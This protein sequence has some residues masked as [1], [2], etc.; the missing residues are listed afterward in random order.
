MEIIKL[1]K[2]KYKENMVKEGI[3]IFWIFVIG[4]LLG[5]IYEIIIT[6]FKLG[7]FE[8]RQGL[9]YGPFIP[10]Y[11]IGGIAYYIVLKKLKIQKIWQVFFVSMFLGGIT[12]YICSFVQ[13]KIWGTISW[14]YSYLPFNLNG[15]TSLL[16]CCYWGIAGILYI[17]YIYPIVQKID[18]IIERKS[19]LAITTIFV[20]FMVF[21]IVI[22]TMA[23]YRQ[24]QRFNNDIANNRI[25][26]WFDKTYPDEYLN[27]VFV[28][29]K[30]VIRKHEQ[31]INNTSTSL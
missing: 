9:I 16:H 26:I 19:F 25:E 31:F 27:K 15:R 20:C 11:G 13:E 4:S 14:D 1:E 8:N 30:Y 12:E 2:H 7:H 10:V 23:A 29:K 28:N 3:K 22:S 6:Y 21:N 18:L 17:K 5:Y 24:K